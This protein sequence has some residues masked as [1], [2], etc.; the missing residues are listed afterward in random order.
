MFQWQGVLHLSKKIWYRK[1][2]SINTASKFVNN[3]KI[4]NPRAFVIVQLTLKIV[5]V[6]IWLNIQT[7]FF[8]NQKSSSLVTTCF[9][10]N[11]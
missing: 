5:G 4:K 10:S 2:D 8:L 1:N 7:L 11:H 6:V 9:L 3:E